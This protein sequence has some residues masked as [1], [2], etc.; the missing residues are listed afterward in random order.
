MLDVAMFCTLALTA[1]P[2][3]AVGLAPALSSSFC[4]VFRILLEDPGDCVIEL[5]QA[6]QDFDLAGFSAGFWA[7][8]ELIAWRIAAGHLV[9]LQLLEL[10]QILGYELPDEAP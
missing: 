1:V 5:G 7:P 10:R 6:F 2:S 4:K 3:L 8:R 9:V